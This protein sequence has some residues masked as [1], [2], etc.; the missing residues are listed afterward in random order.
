MTIRL[1]SL[2]ITD[3][4]SPLLPISHNGCEDE[5]HLPFNSL[6]CTSGFDLRPCSQQWL[7]IVG[8]CLEQT[9]VHDNVQYHRHCR[10]K[11]V[12]IGAQIRCAISP[13]KNCTKH[14]V[15]PSKSC[16]QEWAVVCPVVLVDVPPADLNT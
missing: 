2:P 9:A 3:M 15:A 6:A 4:N 7:N 5:L 13:V 11:D 16:I 1:Q 12:V 8:T 14:E 10:A